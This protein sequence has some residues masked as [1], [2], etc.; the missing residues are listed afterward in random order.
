MPNVVIYTTAWCPY[1]LRA[2]A[3]LNSK[4]VA[5]E[6]ISVDGNPTLRAEMASKA[7]RTSV[8]QIWIGERHIGG[9]DDLVALERA[10]RLDPL[11]Q[12]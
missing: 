2:K 6:E 11:L 1:C 10:G 8:P 9:C 4:N 7:G 3:L 12:A 5:Y